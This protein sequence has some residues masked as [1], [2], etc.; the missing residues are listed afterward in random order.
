MSTRANHTI[1][2]PSTW[3]SKA[4]PNRAVR[5][6]H[7]TTPG[8][9]GNAV[10]GTGAPFT[11]T[12]SASDPDVASFAEFLDKHDEFVSVYDLTA[13]AIVKVTC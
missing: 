4:Q 7:C 12:S 6:V 11:S 3:A 10:T 5:L 8:V 1:E 9:P 2:S 13:D